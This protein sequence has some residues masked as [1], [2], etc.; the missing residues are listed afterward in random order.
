M[1]IARFVRRLDLCYAEAG[2]IIAAPTPYVFGGGHPGFAPS[3]GLPDENPSSLVGYDC[4]GFASAVLK[5]GGLLAIPEARLALDTAE[6]VSWGLPGEGAYLTLWVRND[7]I[8]QH[9]F[10]DF[11]GRAGWSHRYAE[12][13]HAP[14]LCRWDS[15]ESF[16]GFA[17]RHWPGT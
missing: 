11:H 2:R 14:L 7:A 1:T 10:L 4:S 12:A 15:G 8:Q 13:P 9:C 3:T 5:A 6:F 16:T 17:P